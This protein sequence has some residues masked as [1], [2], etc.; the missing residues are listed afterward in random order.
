M[1]LESLAV[2]T[3]PPDRTPEE[4]ARRLERLRKK[5]DRLNRA[6]LPVN[7]ASSHKV[8]RPLVYRRDLP[9][10]LARPRAPVGG[11]CIPLED[12]L[13]GRE[14]RVAGA[15][16]FFLIERPAPDE[17]LARQLAAAASR[18]PRATEA[19][20]MCFLDVET[21][22]LGAALVFLIGTLTWRDG[23]LTC[24]QLLA[25]TYA[26][27]AGIIA[28]FAEDFRHRP[29]LVTFNGKAFDIPSLRARAVV[30]GVRLPDPRLHFDLLHAARRRFKDVLPDC[31][32]QTLERRVCGRVRADDIPGHEIGRAYHDFV[33]TGD[34][35][36]VARVV[37]H[38]QADLLTLA[39]LLVRLT[40]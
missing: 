26:E 20:E 30:A 15:P 24:R 11:I 19:G 39:E 8:A 40:R 29:P 32:L 31:R 3:R 18:L 10:E 17:A 16:A 25:R 6:P 21:T 38:N 4:K 5:L 13:E 34:A 1:G 35:R 2:S 36:E 22:G 28:A 12:C 7:A 27:E 37:R 9:R 33:R 23:L 14:A